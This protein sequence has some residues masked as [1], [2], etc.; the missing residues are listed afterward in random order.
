MVL[1][2][3]RGRRN[4]PAL[5][6]ESL[7]SQPAHVPPASC[8][9]DTVEIP[10]VLD[11]GPHCHSAS[12]LTNFAIR[13][14]WPQD[15]SIGPLETFTSRPLRRATKI[16]GHLFYVLLELATMPVVCAGVHQGC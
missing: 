5:S 7:A 6:Q 13:L 9:F 3:R 1:K 8:L 2:H 10:T 12:S 4:T 15:P 11:K 16:K 14:Y